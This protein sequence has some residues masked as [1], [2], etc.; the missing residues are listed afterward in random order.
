M[1]VIVQIRHLVSSNVTA[2]IDAASNPVT[3]LRQLQ[4]EIEDALVTLEGE[5]SRG[6]RQ[7]ARHLA[8]AEQLTA[9]VDDWNDKAKIAMD[10]NREDLAR[11]AL[12]AREDAKGQAAAE[13]KAA[14]ALAASLEEMR[15][16]RTALEAKLADV[17][18]RHAELAL[19]ASAG[20]T[21]SGDSKTDKLL[22]RIEGL[23]RRV[24]FASEGAAGQSP[25]SI[26][27]ELAALA[28]DKTVDSDLAALKAAAKKPAS[29]KR[30]G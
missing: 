27:A 24:G 13:Q 30:K 11:G 3:M 2:A 5:V 4:R 7:H 28:R 22:D 9:S 10:H 8:K 23:E 25:A 12:L 1:S 20:T 15:S 19:A 14:E 29:R 18:A 16:S 21:Q 26:E 17:R 6:E